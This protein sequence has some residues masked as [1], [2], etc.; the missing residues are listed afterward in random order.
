MDN[1][2]QVRSRCVHADAVVVH[3]ALGESDSYSALYA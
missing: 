2:R 3:V 1:L